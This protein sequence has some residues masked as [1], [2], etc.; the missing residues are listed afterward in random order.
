[1]IDAEVTPQKAVFDAVNDRAER[2][3]EV[4]TPIAAVVEATGLAPD[5][6]LAELVGMATPEFGWI[7]FGAEDEP[8]TVSLTGYAAE[9]LGLRLEPDDKAAPGCVWVPIA[10]PPGRRRRQVERERRKVRLV[11]FSELGL[12]GYGDLDG[13]DVHDDDP[14]LN[15]LLGELVALTVP[16]PGQKSSDDNFDRIPQP[17]MVLMGCRAWVN[18]VE[19]PCPACGDAP[20]G[21]SHYCGR[22]DRFGLDHR[23]AAVNRAE[24]TVKARRE[25]VL[26]RVVESIKPKKGARRGA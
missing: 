3:G 21:R 18:V 24:A 23:V 26:R 5:A 22:C 11:L 9:K 4:V 25:E 15:Q 17:T 6:V 12:E 8:D 16:G 20:L 13:I 2:L 1:M 19:A 7:E 10:T 14:K